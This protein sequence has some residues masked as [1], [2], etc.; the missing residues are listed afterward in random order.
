[1][2]LGVFFLGLF[3]FWGSLLGWGAFAA[4]LGLLWGLF[5][6]WESGFR[7]LVLLGVWVLWVFGFCFVGCV[8]CCFVRNPPILGR[9]ET[10]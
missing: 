9:L 1:M 7:F 4:S 10:L 2:G 3:G 5:C 8:S 6:N